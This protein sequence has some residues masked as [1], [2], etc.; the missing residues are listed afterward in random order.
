MSGNQRAGNLLALVSML[1]VLT[2]AGIVGSAPQPQES[3]HEYF[4][5]HLARRAYQ[6]AE[7][8][9]EGFLREEPD[10]AEA[11]ELL[12]QARQGRWDYEGAAAA[13]RR[14]LDLGRENAALLRGWVETKGRSSGNVGLFFTAGSLRKDLERAL[15]LDPL[16]VES[17]AFLAAFYY[18]VP[19]ILGGD[20]ERADRLI[21]ELVEMS[22]PDGYYILGARA[23][24][25]KEPMTIAV[26]H[27]EKALELDPEHVPALTEL[28]RYWLN[29]K[30]YDRALSL[31]QRA[32]ESA[33]DDPQVLTSYGRALRRSGRRDE[34]AEQYRRALEIDPFWAAARFALAEYHER[35]DEPDAARREYQM[36]ARYNPTYK[37]REIRKRLQRLTR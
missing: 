12:G 13:Y 28:G 20:K 11:W 7:Q 33:P 34:S 8:L 1:L 9:I 35:I 27:W 21:E 16:H 25:E 5:E 17:R 29:Q 15:E 32:V 10:D 23:R 26:G 37:T 36:L 6:E 14:A 3:V 2:P 24:E 19:G 30:E 18:M 31:Y 4:R 22:P